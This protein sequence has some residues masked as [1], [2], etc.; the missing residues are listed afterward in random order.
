M[1]KELKRLAATLAL[2]TNDAYSF[3]RYGSWN[4]VAFALLKAGYSLHEAE[5]IMRSKW[6]RWASDSSDRPYGRA[7]AKC[8]VDYASKQS[9]VD[10]DEI[11]V[12]TGFELE[13]AEGN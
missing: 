7:T 4:A 9:R 1:S 8:L 3:A 10:L 6:A 13:V 11:V 12:G 5:A 2:N